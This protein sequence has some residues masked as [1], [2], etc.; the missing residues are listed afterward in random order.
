GDHTNPTGLQRWVEMQMVGPLPRRF[1][2]HLLGR[3]AGQPPGTTMHD[4][5]ADVATAITREL[6][7]PVPLMGVST[8]GS[9]ALQVAIDHPSLVQRL[10]VVGA[11]ARL[12]D[13][14]RDAQRRL[15]E[16]TE[17]GRPRD[18]WATVGRMSAGS[19]LGGRVMGAMMWLGG[20][21]SDPA[22]P[23][24]MIVTIRAEDAFDV[25][26]DL[27]RI[28]A[29]TLVVGGGRDRFYDQH[30]LR[31]TARRIPDATLVLYPT[32]GHAGVITHR[33]AQRAILQFLTDERVGPRA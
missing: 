33:P 15:A 12:S 19:E 4:L 2:V 21:A 3:R 20:R 10:V 30:V 22:D 9:I 8:G 31:E 25:L 24:D 1:T 17:Q 13:A 11:A 14:G 27:E 26:D 29:P 28:T 18:A 32:K 23:S 6:G 16:L 7:G 5:A